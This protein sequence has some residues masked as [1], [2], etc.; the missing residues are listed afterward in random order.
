MPYVPQENRGFFRDRCKHLGKTA[1]G[2]GDLNYIFSMIAREYFLTQGQNYVII[3][4]IIGALEGAKLEFNRRVVA[5]YEDSKIKIN[6]DL[7]E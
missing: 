2:A 7:D 5:D 6:G 1:G 3:N 4:D